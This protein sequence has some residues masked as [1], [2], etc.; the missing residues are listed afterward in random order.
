M[1]TALKTGGAAGPSGLDA[2]SWKHLCTSFQSS[3]DLCSALSS[4]SRRLCTSYV[5]PA[6]LYPSHLIAI[7]KQPGV[8]PIGV[9]EV[10]RRIIGVVI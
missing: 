8:R 9:G 1:S 4:L 5:D 3:P 2:S 6:D 7:D 10:V